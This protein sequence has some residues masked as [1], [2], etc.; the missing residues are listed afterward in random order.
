MARMMG[1]HFLFLIAWTV[2]PTT[3]NGVAINRNSGWHRARASVAWS[4][5]TTGSQ[6]FRFGALS[7]GHW[8]PWHG[9]AEEVSVMVKTQAVIISSTKQSRNI[10][11]LL[12]TK[13]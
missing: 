6:A 1:L 7:M 11:Y 8:P 12:E 2:R 3:L 13:Q 9:A 10:V 4:D 5:S